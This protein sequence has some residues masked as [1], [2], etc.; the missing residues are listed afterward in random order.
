M[1]RFAHFGV[2]RAWPGLICLALA[3]LLAVPHPALAQGGGTAAIFTD[4]VTIPTYPCVTL[5]QTNTLYG[6][7]YPKN[8][9]CQSSPDPKTY[10]R[11]VLENNFLQLSILPELGGRVYELIFKPT[12]H[13][14]F[15]RNPVIKPSPWGPPEQGG[16]LAAGGLEW[17]LPVA[18]HGYEWG[19]P[20]TYTVI[21]STAGITVTLR[22][23]PPTADRLRAEVAVHLPANQALFRTTHHLEN[24]RAFPL[25]FSY[26][27]NAMLAPGAPN[28][29]TANLRF[30]FPANQVQVHSRDP[31]DN[32]LPP[33]KGVMIWPTGPGRDMSRLGNWNG[34]FGFFAYPQSQANFTGVYDPSLGEGVLH[35]FPKDTVT[36]SKGFAFGWANPIDWH[37]W[38]DDSSG[39]VELHNGPQPTFWDTTRLEAGSSLTYQDVWYPVSGLGAT[40][41]AETQFAAAEAA[42]LALTP[43]ATGL[44][45]ALF[46]PG[47]YANVRV[48]VRRLSNGDTLDDRT[49]A[50]LTPAAARRYSVTGIGLTP[51]AVS[52]MVFDEADRLLTAHN[53]IFDTTPPVSTV[54]PLPNFFTTPTF[55]VQWA[56]QDAESALSSFDVQVRDGVE[57]AWSGWLTRTT[58]LSATY[59]GQNG[60]TYFFRVRAGDTAGNV[61][62][63]SHETWGQAFTSVLLTPTPVLVTSRKLT[64]SARLAPG[65]T[66]T[67]TL[68][69]SNSGSISAPLRIT[70]TLPPSLALLTDTLAAT[71]PPLPTAAAGQIGWQSAISAGETVLLIYQLQSP[72][73]SGSLPA[74]VNTLQLNDGLHPVF[75]RTTTVWPDLPVWLPLVLRDHK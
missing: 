62:P 18:E 20:W 30:I 71:R 59:V 8:Q 74:Q 45:V 4:T 49:F 46:S 67:Y 44:D 60:H 26:W 22:D 38:T 33:E 41:S 32:F 11:L 34:W 52:V 13:N 72:A 54:L 66:L 70:D 43:T 28:A 9:S 36:G 73:I 7:S 10:T 69:L 35:V 37:N 40:I 15:Y 31:N 58:A 14:Q 57:A 12:G 53:P 55:T 17:G 51:A 47:V 6:I 39:Y 56:G 75:T 42:A 21:T 48:R 68:I 5:T 63:L 24:G 61:E 25:N 19:L 23:S 50:T 16:W 29:P 64:N 3:L 1:K 27:T 65:V 2:W